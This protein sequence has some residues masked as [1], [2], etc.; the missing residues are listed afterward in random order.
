MFP[1]WPRTVQFVLVEGLILGSVLVWVSVITRLR[2]GRSLWNLSETTLAPV[3]FSV[4]LGVVGWL[5]LQVALRLSRGTEPSPSISLSGIQVMTLINLMIAVALPAMLIEGGQRR[6]AEIGLSTE[7]WPQQIV[8]GLSGF[9]AAVIPTGALLLASRFWRTQE[10]Q[11]AFLQAL[12][13]A[14]DWNIVVWIVLSAAIA[15][16]LAEELLFRVVL[17]GWLSERLPGSVAIGITAVIFAFVHGWRDAL[18]LIPLSLILG[19]LYHRTHHYWSCVVTHAAFNATNLA[20]FLLT[21][22]GES[23]SL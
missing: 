19:I 17:Q 5:V 9:L 10:T 8:V 22:T 13:D 21:T 3:R 23:P 18:P 16:P 7:Q 15:A 4:L 20:M 2:T 6:F 1:S 12:R 11:H 14:S